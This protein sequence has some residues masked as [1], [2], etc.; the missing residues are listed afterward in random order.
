MSSLA[1][2]IAT[3]TVA[4]VTLAVVVAVGGAWMVSQR[5]AS[6]AVTDSLEASQAVQRYLQTSRARE[7]ALTT[8]L[9][10]A[11]PHDTAYLVEATRGQLGDDEIDRRSILD[12]IDERRR[13]MGFDFSMM[14][15][16]DGQVLVR[17]DRPGVAQQ[18][19]ASH[20]LVAP[21]MADLVPEYGPWREGNRLFS[22]A[23]VPITT[24]FELVGFL[25][26]GLAINDDVAA[27][28]KHVSGIDIAYFS[29]SSGRPALAA[30]TLNLR[31][32]ERLLTQIGES[33]GVLARLTAGQAV[34]RMDV[35]FDGENWVA[36][37]EPLTD[38]T[39]EVLGIVLTLDSLDARLAGHR[40]TQTTLLG[41]GV[42]AVLLALILSIL[43]AR[44]IARPV[45]HL[46]DVADQAAQGEYEQVIDIRGKDEIA[47][48]SRA[49]SRLLADLR[50]QQEIAGYVSDL[51][52][53]LEEPERSAS[54]SPDQNQAA[55]DSPRSGPV[56]VLALQWQAD[57]S[58]GAQQ[59]M[60]SLENWLP[61]LADWAGQH[62]AHLIPG[63]SAR[64][65]LIFD[66][67]RPSG[68]E[69]CLGDLLSECA[70]RSDPPAMALAS[71]DIISTDVILGG[72]RSNL[73]SGK[74][75]FHCERLLVE[76]GMGRLLLSPVVYKALQSRLTELAAKTG[77][78]Q[79]RVSNRKF[80]QL[81][82]IETS[83]ATD[84]SRT[85][86]AGSLPIQ[87]RSVGGS[88]VRIGSVLGGRY[89]VLER[90]G[91]GAMG[92]V[93][94]ARDRKLDDIVAL[95][96]L[97]PGTAG[98]HEQQER[99]KSE[100]RLARR[101]THPNVLRTHD[102]WE[103]DGQPVISM[104]YVRGI[105]LNQL[106]ENSGRLRLAAGLRVCNQV[107]QGLNAAHQAGVLHR[108][109]KPANIILDQ[110]GN[111]RLMDF[112][113]SRQVINQ[114]K[115]LTQPGTIVGTANYLAPEVLLGETADQRSD[116][117]SMGVMMTE[118]F[119]GQLP[120]TGETSMQVCMAHIQQ[121]PPRPSE[122]WSEIPPSLENII[123]KCLAK[124]PNQRYADAESLLKELILVRRQSAAATGD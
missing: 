123:L 94:K 106:L 51:S 3:V 75:V 67:D 15:G 84:P 58:L 91:A 55:M 99:M 28:I 116:L 24:A 43:M 10:A 76:A 82:A 54:N 50:E 120:F 17:T 65:Y 18:S 77:L 59:A 4:L 34:E 33:E 70:V 109:I 112:G 71:G 45:S 38:A 83:R 89:E 107:L 117:Y 103:I 12:L 56:V 80:Y 101:I 60:Q 37:A 68:L 13:E 69:H 102:F 78:T 113:I 74:P 52:R 110:S 7:L 32:G 41:A 47:T 87:S 98:D 5:V 72:N 97:T 36:R 93:F 95:K 2:R 62:R 20:P 119:T 85:E 118:I 42:V 30:S 96:M 64:L 111:A 48:L 8:D 88:K 92:T 11:D 46:A 73:I 105:T 1:S 27:D 81:L 16:P 35:N 9:L 44:R 29:L 121:E 63:G 66:P 40:T 86:M 79:G 100:I 108:D 49:I 61:T 21:V 26:T 104:E 6:E 39:G 122:A 90:I 25:V 114:D 22:V 31:R 115:N 57:A 23:V 19:L 14:L 124:K 53:H